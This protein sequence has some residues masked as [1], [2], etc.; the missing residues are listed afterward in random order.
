MVRTLAVALLVVSGSL[1]GCG[2][3]DPEEGAPPTIARPLAGGTAEVR[4][5]GDVRDRFEVPLDPE[6]TLIYRP[7]EGGFALSW[8]SEGR[9][10]GIGG[11][12]FTGTRATD[13]GLSVTVS[14]MS[15]EF[16]VVFPSVDGQ[17]DVTI[18]GAD[19]DGIGGSFECTG[20][21]SEGMRVD[22]RGSFSAQA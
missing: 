6:A 16:P 8:A 22:A 11:L 18:D 13:Q 2:G 9:G 17:C 19:R 4:V 1:A 12:L 15:G 10:L 3:D 7:P 20:L 21:W 5:T 14:T